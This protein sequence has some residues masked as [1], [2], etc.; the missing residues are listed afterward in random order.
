MQSIVKYTTNVLYCILSERLKLLKRGIEQLWIIGDAFVNSSVRTH[1]PVGP[2]AFS[3]TNFD[4]HITAGSGNS[5]C[6]NLVARI[7]NGIINTFNTQCTI[8]KWIVIVLEDDIVKTFK[9]KDENYKPVLEF[10]LNSCEQIVSDMIKDLPFKAIKYSW[11]FIMFIE[12]S[13]NCNYENNDQRIKFNQALHETI[14][15]RDRFISVPL[16]QNWM[17][18]D[19]ELYRHHKRCHTTRGLK[20]FWTSVDQTIRFADTKMMRN[21][22]LSLTKVFKKDKLAEEAEEKFKS[23]NHQQNIDLRRRLDRLANESFNYMRRGYQQERYNTQLE[24]RRMIQSNSVLSRKCL[25][26]K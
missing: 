25:F 26:N 24:R 13:I 21:H 5:S 22:G 6:K 9:S 7:V 11:P 12:S 8:P 14:K 1:L 4:T 18:N 16:R 15:G 19:G 2:E 3:T 20:T 23:F 10:I 17:N